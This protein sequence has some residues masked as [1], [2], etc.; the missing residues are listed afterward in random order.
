MILALVSGLI[1]SVSA[2]VSPMLEDI[3]GEQEVLVQTKDVY[4]HEANFST[5]L[6]IE[7]R[8]EEL[9]I[10]LIEVEGRDFEKI[11]NRS[12]IESVEPNYRIATQLS[13]TASQ[14]NAEQAWEYNATGENVTV[15]VIDSGVSNHSYLEVE[16][17]IDFTGEGLGD[18]N[19]HGTHVAGIVGS[20]HPNYRGIAYESSL[21][22]LK[23]LDESGRG[24][25]DRLLRALD[26]TIRN[27]ID[28]TVLS[29]GTQV[30]NCN[31]QDAMSK[32]VNTASRN[33]VL[34]VVAAGNTGPER[35]TVTAPGCASEALTVG[36]VDKNNNVGPYSSRGPTSD[37]RTKPDV[38]APGTNIGSTSNN[39]GLV[40]MSGTSMAAPHV[41]GQAAVLISTGLK[42]KEAEQ[43]IIE[44]AVDIGESENVQG[45]GRVDIAGSLD[46]EVETSSRQ[47]NW[48][49]FRSWVLNFF[50][51][52]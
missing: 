24:R 39:G 42:S 17:S 23:V 48:E 46:I 12:F 43:R 1:V 10:A 3:E 7:Q 5:D 26:Y 18:S 44:S 52:I 2:E 49:R 4:I 29:L 27:D 11:D 9:E 20:T 13:D 38:V 50:T 19:G 51:G 6:D 16:D 25:A 37:G 40:R 14:I 34:T 36:A 8:Y 30:E 35:K 47:S 21:Y 15:S 28:V 41:A 33:G 22:D 45:A 32:A 31:G